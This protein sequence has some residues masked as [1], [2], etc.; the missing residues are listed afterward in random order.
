MNLQ[1]QDKKAIV[2]GGSRG[3]GKAIARQLAREG[4][5]VAICAREEGPLRESAEEL[6][7]ETGRKI[8]PIL[9]D[10]MNAE[11][12]KA[13][14]RRAAGELGGIHIVINSA[15]RV[16]GTPGTIETVNDTDVLRDFEEKS[17]ATCAVPRRRFLI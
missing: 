14:V 7:G 4:C 8:V 6:A 5:D 17:S 10:T 16:S 11:A 2:T 12:I 9:C 15:A 3:I 13:F 1:L